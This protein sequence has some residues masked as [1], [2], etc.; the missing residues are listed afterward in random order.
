MSAAVEEPLPRPRLRLSIPLRT[1]RLLAAAGLAALLVVDA[2]LLVNAV[3]VVSAGRAAIADPFELDFAEGLVLAPTRA[4]SAGRSIYPPAGDSPALISNYTPVYYA[5]AAA[6]GT[7][8]GDHLAAGRALSLASTVLAALVLTLLAWRAIEPASGRRGRGLA[9]VGAGLGFLQISYTATFAALMRVDLLAVLLAFSG[10]L[11]FGATAARGRRVYWCLAPFLLAAYTKQTTVA[12]AAACILTASRRS[13]RRG[14]ALAGALAGAAALAGGALQL[15][16][17]GGFAFHV[18][19]ANLHPYNWD[20][21]ASFL[22]DVAIRYPVLVAL[23]LA[24][25]PQ[26]L[27]SLPR[28]GAADESAPAAARAWTRAALGAYLPLAALTSLTV[29][30]LGAEVNYLIEP[31]GVICVCAAVAVGDALRWS[32]S[33]DA[34]DAMHAGGRTLASIAVPALLLWQVV[35]LAPPKTVELIETPPADEQARL[36][37]L[38][39]LVRWVDGPVLSEDLTLLSLAGKPILFQPCDIAQLIYRHVR[40]EAPWVEALERGDFR[41][42]VLRFDVRHPPPPAFARFTPAMIEAIRT[43]YVPSPS[44]A[45]GYWVYVPGASPRPEVAS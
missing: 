4:L 8:V 20:Q 23:A 30:K 6:L 2:I 39:D 40:D 44:A 24:T 27:A 15:G 33:A 10:V 43:H 35:G 1:A 17:H 25:V 34:A 3:R 38:V 14:I 16:T 26:L 32:D 13:L 11:V 45:S 19:T 22:Q 21:T 36:A 5:A 42:V 29:G 7:A 12:A 28:E 41:L 18:I 9:A 37:A 31:L